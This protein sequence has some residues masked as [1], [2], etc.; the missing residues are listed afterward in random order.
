M[1]IYNISM[2]C[3]CTGD[4]PSSVQLSASTIQRIVDINA[5]EITYA[6]R[7][8]TGL[9]VRIHGYLYIY[10]YIYIYIY[11]YVYIYVYIYI[12]IYIYIY[13]CMYIFIYV[14]IFTHIFTYIFTYINI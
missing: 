4:F 6:S 12:Y 3:I 1:F 13:M 9:W 2:L 7:N 11:V 8:G 5:F 14:Y 10:I